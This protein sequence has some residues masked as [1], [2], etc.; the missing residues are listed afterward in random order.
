MSGRQADPSDDA[1]LQV[2]VRHRPAT[3]LFLSPKTAHF[4]RIDGSESQA[5]VRLNGSSPCDV[6]WTVDPAIREH[7]VGLWLGD[8]RV[9]MEAVSEGSDRDL[10]PYEG[11]YS[12]AELD[13]TY[14]VQESAKGIRLRNANP[15]HPSM[16]LEYAPT[17]PDFFWSHDPHP[18]VSQIQFLR[19]GN[20]LSGF[21]YRDYDGDGRESFVFQ[22][23]GV[24]TRTTA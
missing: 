22:R 6:A 11:A 23:K 24:A 17:L 4:A 19:E 21:I 16:D 7:Q 20:S 3:G 14:W 15:E 9:E 5:T 10:S 2:D 18:G 8:L 1:P 12:C 13:C